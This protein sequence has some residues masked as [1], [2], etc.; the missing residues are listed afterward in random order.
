MTDGELQEISADETDLTESARA[1]L[2]AE[3]E[4]RGLTANAPEPSGGYDE[5]EFRGLETARR[6]RGLAE[7]LVA[8]SRLDSA[9][10]ESL[11]VDDNMGRIFVTTFTGGVRLQVQPEDLAE[12]I[13]ILDETVPEDLGLE[14]DEPTQP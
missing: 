7:A 12:A 8:K 2:R 5:V 4:R 14:G 6:F 3:L 11:L 10:I 9:A 1:A 13:A